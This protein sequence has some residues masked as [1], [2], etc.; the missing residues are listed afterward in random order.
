MVLPNS[1]LRTYLRPVAIAAPAAARLAASC[2]AASS[3]W[4][5]AWI[6]SQTL[7][8]PKKAVGCTAPSVAASSAALRQK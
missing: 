8:T 6:F 1:Q 2:S 5:R 4:M 3:A 7:G